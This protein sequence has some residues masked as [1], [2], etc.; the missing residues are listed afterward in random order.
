M[1]APSTQPISY[2]AVKDEDMASD[3]NSGWLKVQNTAARVSGK[4]LLG[5]SWHGVTGTLDGVINI[6]LSNDPSATKQE[7]LVEDATYAPSGDI[8][9]DSAS[10]LT[11]ILAIGLTQP[12]EYMKIIYTKNNITAGTLRVTVGREI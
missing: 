9:V 5:I 4:V 1:A 6:K 11:N 10:N 3:Y 2:R 7:D 8:T 12:F